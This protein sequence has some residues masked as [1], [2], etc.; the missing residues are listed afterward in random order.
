IIDYANKQEIPIIS[1]NYYKFL[2]A[3]IINIAMYN[4]MIRKEILI[5]EDIVKPIND[6]TVVFDEMG[7][8]DYISRA[9]VTGHSR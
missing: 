6:M 2:V 1:S 3:K 4:Q 5:V 8:D 9:K 7:L